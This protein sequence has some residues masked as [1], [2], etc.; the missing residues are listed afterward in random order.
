MTL[1]QTLK[2][3]LTCESVDR[4]SIRTPRHSRYPTQLLR[5]PILLN[6]ESMNHS[7]DAQPDPAGPVSF[8]TAP[9]LDY[10]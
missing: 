9:Y 7:P 1:P 2:V 5:S 10:Y 3:G 4:Y 8:P 6:S